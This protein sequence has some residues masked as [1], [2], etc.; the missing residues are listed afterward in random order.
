MQSLLDELIR[1]RGKLSG[2]KLARAV[3]TSISLKDVQELDGLSMSNLLDS[4]LRVLDTKMTDAER[5]QSYRELTCNLEKL[6]PLPPKP[7]QH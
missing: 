5:A 6:R 3:V 2:T 4:A 7:I 1:I